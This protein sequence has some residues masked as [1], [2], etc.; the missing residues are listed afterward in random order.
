LHI[1]G[2]RQFDR[3]AHELNFFAL[4][5]GFGNERRSVSRAW[6][7]SAVAFLEGATACA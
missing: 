5:Q 6:S 3:F 7:S 1:T 2:F 4:K